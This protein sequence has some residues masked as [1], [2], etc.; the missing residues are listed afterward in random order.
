VGARH[1]DS[2]A[3]PSRPTADARTPPATMPHKHNPRLDTTYSQ[4]DVGI[5]GDAKALPDAWDLM[6][7]IRNELAE[8]SRLV[9]TERSAD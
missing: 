9:T 2:S 4:L 7:D 3:T 1:P 5:V 8:L 6:A